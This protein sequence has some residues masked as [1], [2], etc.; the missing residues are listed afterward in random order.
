[1][2][3][4]FWCGILVASATWCFSLYLYWLL[5]RGQPNIGAGPLKWAQIPDEQNYVAVQH[6]DLLK[7]PNNIDY[8]DKIS[9]DE[10]DQQNL[11][12]K[13]KK[14][15]KFQKISQHLIDELKPVEVTGQG[16]HWF[17]PFN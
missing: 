3:R 14:E 17:Y 12:I 2:S 5:T 10:E 16:M 6:K 13:H 1:M 11:Y 15:K 4:S 8:D 7:G 9:R